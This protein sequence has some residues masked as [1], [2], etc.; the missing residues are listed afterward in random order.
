M[1]LTILSNISRFFKI[2]ILI[3]LLNNCSPYFIIFIPY[4]S[5]LSFEVENFRDFYDSKWN[6]E[7]F[8]HEYLDIHEA[9]MNNRWTSQKFY[10]EI[11]Q[12]SRNYESFLPRKFGAIRYTY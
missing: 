12:N 10:H 5:K 8:I 11:L 1:L 9:R 7:N 2:A 3:Q 6:H 4:S